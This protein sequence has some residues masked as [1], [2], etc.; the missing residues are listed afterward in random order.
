MILHFLQIYLSKLNSNCIAWSKQQGVLSSMW[1]QTEFTCFKQ[2]GAISTLSGKSLK[3][4]D[5]FPY[6]NSTISSTESDVNICRVKAWTAIDRL[7]II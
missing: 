4:V 3:L 5:Q 7:L 1:M 6:L 2:E